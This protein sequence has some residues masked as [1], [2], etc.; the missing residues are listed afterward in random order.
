[1]LTQHN[2]EIRV[3][4]HETDAQ[5][6]VHHASYLNYFEAGRIELLR[7][8]GISYRQLEE[9]GTLLVVAKISCKYHRPAFYDD[10]LTLT[11]TTVRARA[12]RV[13]HVYQ[14]RRD[15]QLL[16]EGESVIAC[17]DRQGTVRRIPD[18]MQME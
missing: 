3:R 15:A 1:M 6:R 13:E 7:A 11:T 18:W 16:V 2:L 12:A 4:Y 8:S 17:I 14:L 9:E 10:I 5:G